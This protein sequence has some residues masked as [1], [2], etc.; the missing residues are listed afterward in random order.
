MTATTPTPVDL[1]DLVIGQELARTRHEITRDTLV[2][3]AGA[4]GTSTP[5]TTTTPSPPR[6]GSWA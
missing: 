3:Y 1:A 5:S 2:R 6:P 4:S